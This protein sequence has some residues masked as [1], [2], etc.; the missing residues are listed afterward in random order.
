MWKSKPGNVAGCVLIWRK[1]KRIQWD[2]CV[3]GPCGK[4]ELSIGKI[5]MASCPNRPGLS[6]RTSAYG[7]HLCQATGGEKSPGPQAERQKAA[8]DLRKSHHLNKKGFGLDHLPANFFP[9]ECF[10]LK[11]FC[12][13]ASLRLNRVRRDSLLILKFQDQKLQHSNQAV[14][15]GGLCVPGAQEPVPPRCW[16]QLIEEAAGC[17]VG[18]AAPASRQY[19][20]SVHN[21]FPGQK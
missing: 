8:C 5:G 2:I 13:E 12:S 15:C 11:T 1:E 16:V 20:F 10:P 21:A 18:Y 7:T 17:H 9:T 3:Q 19:R 6:Q 14:P 4:R